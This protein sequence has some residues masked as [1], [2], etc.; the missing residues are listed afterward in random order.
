MPSSHSVMTARQRQGARRRSS[1]ENLNFRVR[2]RR[3]GTVDEGEEACAD[4]EDFDEDDDIET[5]SRP[6]SAIRMGEPDEDEPP[7]MDREESQNQN[8]SDG[9]SVTVS[10]DLHVNHE[11]PKTPTPPTASTASPQVHVQPLPTTALHTHF[12][13]EVFAVLQTYRGLPLLD[14]LE[15]KVE[16]GKPETEGETQQCVGFGFECERDGRSQAVSDSEYGAYGNTGPEVKRVARLRTFVASKFWLTTLFVMDFL[17]NRELRVLLANWL[18]DFVKN[19]IFGEISGCIGELAL[20]SDY[21]GAINIVK[22]LRKVAKECKR[23]WVP[24][25]PKKSQA[26]PAE[27]KEDGLNLTSPSSAASFPLPTPGATEPPGREHPLGE[28]FA[29]A[30][31]ALKKTREQKERDEDSDADLDFVPDHIAATAAGLHIQLVADDQ[32]SE[33]GSSTEDSGS[34]KVPSTPRHPDGTVSLSSR[35]SSVSLARTSSTDSF[36]VPLSATLS[37]AMFPAFRSPWQFDIVSLDELSDTSSNEDGGRDHDPPLPPG[38]P[39]APN[40]SNQHR[41]RPQRRLPTRRVM[42]VTNDDRGTVSS[43][44]IVSRHSHAS[45]ASTSSV[46][47]EED[48][49]Q[50]LGRGIQQWQLNELVDSSTDDEELG[51]WKMR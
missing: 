1:S 8:N 20:S 43:M 14:R 27:A 25:P 21:L 35:T 42:E 6:P 36:G 50:G 11:F 32:P 23:A 24:P 51:M 13:T 37:S 7:K 17:N 48:A 19:P 47:G 26:S 41:N 38:L 45:T 33:E 16:E 9:Q 31:L 40:F 39:G 49:G 3:V 29:E 5:P 12:S 10:D 4:G 15:A 30:A 34:S 28:R 18:N 2:R 46:G 44:G 22:K